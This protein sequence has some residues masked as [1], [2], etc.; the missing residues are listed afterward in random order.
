MTKIALSALILAAA[1]GAASASLY[2]GLPVD[3]DADSLTTAQRVAIDQIVAS[4]E[5]PLETLK[6]IQ[7]VIK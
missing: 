7:S 4:T 3:I 5:S 1:A 6:Q 2:A